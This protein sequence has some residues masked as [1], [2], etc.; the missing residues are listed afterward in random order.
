MANIVKH[1][2]ASPKSDGPDPTQIQ[3]SNWNDG[4]AFTG[5]NAGDMLTR[6]PSDATYGAKWSPGGLWQSYAPLWKILSGTPP[7]LG[8]GTLVGRYAVVGKTCHFHIDLGFGSTTINGS[9]IY[10]FTMPVAAPTSYHLAFSI[11]AYLASTY[12]QLAPQ[13][14]GPDEF[15]MYVIGTGSPWSNTVPVAPVSGNHVH[16]TGTYEVA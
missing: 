10:V 3:P 11:W 15:Y 5:G 16:V 2:F 6:D 1:R 8:N 7:S 14:G 4:H 9:G 13:I 12:Y